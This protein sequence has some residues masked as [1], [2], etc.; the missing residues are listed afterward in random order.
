MN[1]FSPKD[2]V[3]FDVAKGE[4]R[5]AGRDRTLLVTSDGLTGLLADAPPAA[6][7]KFG[8]SVGKSV[9]ATIAA[10][11]GSGLL[12][13][14]LE[15]LTTELAGELSVRGFGLVSIEQWGRAIV[16]HLENS[17]LT[18]GD[19]VSAVLEGALSA[20]TGKP[21]FVTSIGSGRHLFSGEAAAARAKEL[22]GGGSDYK[23]VLLKLQE[24]S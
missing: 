3:T 12:S 1:T 19:F 4:V 10:R 15:G 11:A 13:G 6:R 2:A 20:M 16:F 22:V 5:T 23:G 9:G 8:A 18:D 21:V 7:R 24:R 14:S 17:A